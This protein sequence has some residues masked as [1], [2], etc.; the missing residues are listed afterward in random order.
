MRRVSAT[1]VAME[2][3]LVLHNLVCVFVAFVIQHAMGLGYMFICGPTRCTI[4][5]Q[6]V[7]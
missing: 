3:Q 5:F 4:F 2:K 7:S 1:I 6:I